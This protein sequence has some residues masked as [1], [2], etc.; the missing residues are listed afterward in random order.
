[1]SQITRE[2][3]TETY[4][5]TVNALPY[6]ERDT[7]QVR[8]VLL[9]LLG[10]VGFVLLIACANITNLLLVKASARAR[11]I[12]VRGALGAS[13][14]RLVRQFVVESM[15]LGLAGAVGG[16]LV[17]WAAV[18]AL[19]AL[20]PGHFP[21]W[22]EFAPDVRMLAFVIA[23]T[24]GTSVVAGMAPA[25]SASRLNLVETLKEG[26]R[27]SSSGGAA[28]GL[29]GFLVVAEVAL[30]VL[31]LVGAGLM[32]QTF[33][34]LNRQ[35]AGF[36]TESITTLQTSAPNNR[37]PNGPAAAELVRRI[38]QEFA[39][40]PGVISVAGATAVPLMNGWW[41]RSFTADG[42]PVVGLKDAPLINH[43][44]VTPGISRHSGSHFG[45]PGFRRERQPGAAGHD[46]RRG[47]RQA[48]L[49]QP[50]RRGQAR[51]L[52][53]ARGQ[54]ALAHGSRRDRRGAQL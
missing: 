5:Q 37:Y 47:T 9:T 21:R 18:P 50:E 43:V 42:R 8:P 44:V 48:L 30:S 7:Q 39:A 35:N 15:L 26:G 24:A 4:G 46:H 6:R 27:T 22:I 53:T 10:A 54:R 14:A 13:R 17:A 33:W 38:R 29:R 1:M 23:V 31:L 40:L 28:A 12:A 32:I 36:R 34:K 2:H 52:R 11:E 16:I 41:G 25:F 3:P 20:A 45:R 51:A 49:A 19:L